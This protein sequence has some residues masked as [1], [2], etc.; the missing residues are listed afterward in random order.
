MTS[1]DKTENPPP[2]PVSTTRR[3]R[4]S[5]IR[6]LTA[7]AMSNNSSRE[8]TRRAPVCR[9]IASKTD[10]AQAYA[11]GKAA[12]ELALKGRNRPWFVTQLIGNLRTA[13]LSWLQVRAA[14]PAG[15]W[16]VRMED[17]DR[18]TSSQEHATGQLADLAAIG[19]AMLLMGFFAGPAPARQIVNLFQSLQQ[20]LAARSIPPRIPG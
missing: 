6:V 19:F 5:R 11:V 10:V 14:V 1:A 15:E 13:L 2:P 20:S 18:V 7:T 16:L 17:L 9:H 8:S 4:T 3:P 12:V